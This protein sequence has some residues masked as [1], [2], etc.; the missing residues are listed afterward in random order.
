ML[1]DT[2]VERDEIKDKEINGPKSKLLD[3]TLED[4]E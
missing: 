4:S 2:V 3:I 1:L